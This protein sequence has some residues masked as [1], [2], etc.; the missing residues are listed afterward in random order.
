MKHPE[1]TRFFILC[2]LF[3]ALCAADGAAQTAGIDRGE[4]DASSR[5]ALVAYSKKYVGT[6]YRYGGTDAAGMDCSGFLTTVANESIGLRLPR[7]VAAIYSAAR[8]ID[9]SKKEAGDI[10]FFR[11]VGTKISHAGLYMGN[12]QFIHAASDGPNTGVIVSSLKESYWRERYA[13][14]GQVLGAAGS[15]AAATGGTETPSAGSAAGSAAGATASSGRSGF[16]QHVDLD[17]TL[18]A[19]WTL[20][21][22]ERAAFISRGGSVMFHAAYNGWKVKPGLGLGLGYDAA[23]S[24]FN[25]PLVISLSVEPGFRI[26]FG[27]VFSFGKTHLPDTGTEITPSVFPGIIGVS[28]RTP[29]L[30]IKTVRLA[31]VQDIHFQIYN[32]KD[33][34][35]LAARESFAAGLVFSTGIRVSF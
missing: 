30:T 29:Q 16:L 9:D 31:L 32:D 3:C 6:P 35:A 11:T 21:S 13:G 34:V 25:I 24:A 22:T 33:K 17:A 23:T 19:D 20:F 8:I 2:L 18:T 7:T 28:W 27:P 14:A 10:V 15:G 4:A 5:A 1:G 26:Y 12:D